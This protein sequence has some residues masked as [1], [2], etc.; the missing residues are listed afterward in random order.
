MSRSLAKCETRV[1]TGATD[2]LTC[3]DE[4]ISTGARHR[5]SQVSSRRERHG[6]REDRALDVYKR[7]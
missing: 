2:G 5:C 3:T 6:R 7:R 1:R 4:T